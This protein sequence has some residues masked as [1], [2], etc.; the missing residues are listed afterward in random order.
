[1]GPRPPPTTTHVRPMRP[2]MMNHSPAPP[3]MM[4]RMKH[5]GPATYHMPKPMP[6]HGPTQAYPTYEKEDYDDH[7]YE[8]YK[9]PQKHGYGLDTS[10]GQ[11]LAEVLHAVVRKQRLRRGRG[12]LSGAF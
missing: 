9:K 5:M 11:V 10:Y 6:K 7:K 8:R 2:M 4:H 12:L 3:R 1:M